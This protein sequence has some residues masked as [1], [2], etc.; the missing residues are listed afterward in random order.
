MKNMCGRAICRMDIWFFT[1]TIL[2]PLDRIHVSGLAIHVRLQGEGV[3]L[4][5]CA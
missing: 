5:M 1:H 3:G 2:G 4:G